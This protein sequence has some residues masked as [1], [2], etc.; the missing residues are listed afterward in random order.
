MMKTTLHWLFRPLIF[1]LA[2]M[3]IIGAGFPTPTRAQSDPETMWYWATTPDGIVAYTPDGE[4]NLILADTQLQHT[5]LTAYRTSAETAL[6]WNDTVFYQV[7][8]NAVLQ[9][10]PMIPIFLEYQSIIYRHPYLVLYNNDPSLVGYVLNI[11]TSEITL[12]SGMELRWS[13]VMLADGH[14][15]RYIST[16]LPT[17]YIQDELVYSLRE[18]DLVTGQEVVLVTGDN[19]KAPSLPEILHSPDGEQWWLANNY[20]NEQAAYTTIQTFGVVNPSFTDWI[21]QG[22]ATIRNNQLWVFSEQCEIACTLEVYPFD[23]GTPY[24]VKLPDLAIAPHPHMRFSIRAVQKLMDDTVILNAS[25]QAIGSNV[26]TW[27]WIPIENN[28]DGEWLEL[29]RVSSDEISL[30]IWGGTFSESDRWALAFNLNEDDSATLRLWRLSHR[31][32]VFKMVVAGQQN[33]RWQHAGETVVIHI[34]DYANDS[35]QTV[36]LA[37]IENGPYYFTDATWNFFEILAD[38]SVLYERLPGPE[39]TQGI[40]RLGGSDLN[41]HTLV[42]PNGTPI[43]VY[44]WMAAE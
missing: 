27:L 4:V 5:K 33:I 29:G 21:K 12:L 11:E 16:D 20:D 7:S 23:G 38:G 3:L 30:R 8:Q 10:Y 41:E 15:L 18:R 19:T 17:P 40:Y 14:T 39:S 34:V 26:G 44:R 13:P 43:P 37:G 2:L 31:E 28:T 24:T 36:I 22:R 9:T 32:M 25:V 42:V 1:A 35:A 6:M